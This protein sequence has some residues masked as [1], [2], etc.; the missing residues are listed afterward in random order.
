MP[1][2]DIERAVLL[3]LSFDSVGE[4]FLPYIAWCL[5]IKCI[6]SHFSDTTIIFLQ[7]ESEDINNNNNKIF[8]KFQL[9][10]T[11][12]FQVMHDVC[13]IASICNSLE[14]VSCG[15]DFLSHFKWF[16]PNSFR[17]V[18]FLEKNYKNRKMFKFWQYW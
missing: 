2:R 4:L 1:L 6:F 10:Q 16:Q 8:P 11:E 17:A 5:V 13:F 9:I 18:G 12:H 7:H 3:D 14:K 15:R